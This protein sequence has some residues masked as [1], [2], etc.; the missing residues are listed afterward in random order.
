M[1]TTDAVKQT[2]LPH[3]LYMINITQYWILHVFVEFG[4]VVD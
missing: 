3:K 1:I 2:A 4:D